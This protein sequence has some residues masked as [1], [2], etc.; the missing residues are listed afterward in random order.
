MGVRA[1][2]GHQ[3][4]VVGVE[5]LGHLQRRRRRRCPGPWRS[6]DPGGRSG[7]PR[8]ARRRHA[9]PGSHRAT[10]RCPARGRRGRSRCWGSRRARPCATRP[11]AAAAGRRAAVEQ[12]IR[13]DA[14]GPVGLGR[15]L[16]FTVRAL[17]WIAVHGGTAGDVG[18]RGSPSRVH[19]GPR[20]TTAGNAHCRRS[21]RAPTTY[22]RGPGCGA[23]PDS[24]RVPSCV[25]AWRPTGRPTSNQLQ[26]ETVPQRG[27][28]SRRPSTAAGE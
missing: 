2:L 17:A 25:A 9:G 13:V 18:S 3:V 27:S 28:D 22:P 19:N 7:C 5:P 4:V 14:T 26:D 16:Q 1:E 21:M 8:R 20:K 24:H 11:G 15:L 23:V 12:G 6:S 10:T